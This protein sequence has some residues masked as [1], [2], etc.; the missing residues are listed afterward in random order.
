VAA[1]GGSGERGRRVEEAGE[2]EGVRVWRGEAE[3]HRAA[4]ARLRHAWAARCHATVEG[5]RVGAT[6]D[7][8]ADRWA[9]MRRSPIVSSWVWGEAAW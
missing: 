7:G 1:E 4:A 3:W 2:S 5:S 9:G 6:W 8:V